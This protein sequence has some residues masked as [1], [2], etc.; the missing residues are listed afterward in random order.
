MPAAA[1][2]VGGF[3]IGRGWEQRKAG[4]LAEARHTAA[5][6]SAFAKLMVKRDPK[7]AVYHL[8]LCEAY[9]QES[10]NAWKVPD[11]TAIE[12]AL[13]KALGEASTA[14]RLDPQ[15]ADARMKV[16]GLQDKL[17]GI[18]SQRH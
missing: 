7:Q 18:A 13:R 11:Y 12:A 2:Q 5:Y 4:R 8:L 14:L 17:I 6:L 10:K 15:N 3:A 1:F 16:A 9:D